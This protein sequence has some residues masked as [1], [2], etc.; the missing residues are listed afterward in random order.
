M[1]FFPERSKPMIKLLSLSKPGQIQRR[2]SSNDF[3]TIYHAV[4]P[5][6]VRAYA[7][8]EKYDR[9]VQ[10]VKARAKPTITAGQS[11]TD[12]QPVAAVERAKK[13]FA[14]AALVNTALRQ[15]EMVASLTR[16]A[17]PELLVQGS[18]LTEP[19]GIFSLEPLTRARFSEGYY[20]GISV[21][22]LMRKLGLRCTNS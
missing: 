9:A 4:Y 19:P 11:S 12:E 18:S 10:R 20:R 2:L 14:D 21:I 17:P 13:L 22:Y 1:P 3:D 15:F 5:P 16:K 6:K 8:I 7:T